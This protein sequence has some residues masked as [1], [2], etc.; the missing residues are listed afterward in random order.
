MSP[1]HDLDLERLRELTAAQQELRA[2]LREL[3]RLSEQQCRVPADR[4]DALAVLLD[5]KQ[6]LLRKLCA[7]EAP[8]LFGDCAGLVA[9]DDADDAQTREA[10]TH[11]RREAEANLERW[12]QLVESEEQARD[13]C[14][15]CVRQL[16]V[17]LS[18]ARRRSALRHAYADPA[19]RQPATPRFVN[20]LR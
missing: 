10:K 20:H 3:G 7:L 9:A 14:A 5:R 4:A 12:K 6:G 8:K 2:A 16:E 19:A 13:H 15:T 18:R 17:E 1:A 11:L